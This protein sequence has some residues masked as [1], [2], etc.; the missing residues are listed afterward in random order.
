MDRFGARRIM[1]CFAVISAVCPI[2]FPALPFLWAVILLQMILGLAD[3]MGWSDAQAMIGLV[4]KGNALHAGRPAFT[5]RIG[6]F[7]G[8]LLIGV[9]WDW[10]V[11]WGAF[12]TLSI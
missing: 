7:L 9:I 10:F 12:N 6:H 4:M 1:L 5:I 2:L 8:P 11:P 3:T